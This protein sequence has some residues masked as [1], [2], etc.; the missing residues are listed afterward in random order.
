MIRT[1][2][3]FSWIL[4]YKKNLKSFYMVHPV[5][6]YKFVIKFFR[7]LVSEKFWKKLHLMNGIHQMYKNIDPDQ[8]AFSPNVLSQDIINNKGFKG[9][10]PPVFGTPLEDVMK[11]DDHVNKEIPIVLDKCITFVEKHG[12][13]EQGIFRLSGNFAEVQKLK[14]L[15]DRGDNNV[16]FDQ[17]S[18]HA[19]TGLMKLLFREMSQPL[20]TFE[21]YQDF[22]NIFRMCK[23]VSPNSIFS[24]IND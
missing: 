13:E 5:W 10:S 9:Y 18:I 6:F 2:I 1:K 24:P 22:T 21:L 14:I 8:L 7:P 20:L 11:R 19:I 4:R 23:T 17:V 15:F 12:L 3:S 16:D